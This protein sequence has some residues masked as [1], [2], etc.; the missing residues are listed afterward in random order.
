M[1]GILPSLNT[2][3]LL[4][5]TLHAMTSNVQCWQRTPQNSKK[6]MGHM[7]NVNSIVTE[8]STLQE[9]KSFHIRRSGHSCYFN[10]SNIFQPFQHISTFFNFSN[11]F[12]HISKFFNIFKP[13]QHIPT[14]CDNYFVTFSLQLYMYRKIYDIK[15]MTVQGTMV[16]SDVWFLALLLRII[17]SS[18]W[19]SG[20]SPPWGEFVI[21]GHGGI[22][23]SA[24]SHHGY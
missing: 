9:M 14:C 20:K 10:L 3:S 12:Q 15:K 22:L 6:S 18:P 11:K 5:L 7:G 21:N 8:N 24:Y 16:R 1:T 23:S 4:L 13:F 17:G 2:A 19:L